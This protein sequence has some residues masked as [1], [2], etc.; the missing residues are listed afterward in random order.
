[1]HDTK[2]QHCLFVFQ[3]GGYV[4][5]FRIDP[6]EKLHEAVKEIQSLYKVYSSAPVFGVEFEVDD[7]VGSN[8]THF[9]LSSCI[10]MNIEYKYRQKAT[11]HLLTTMLSTFKKVLIPG[12][13]HLL[14]TGANDLTL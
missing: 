2:Y 4:L 6:P 14:T 7:K 5:G 9:L 8:N 11:I 10:S 12:Y 3:S 1:M 13:N